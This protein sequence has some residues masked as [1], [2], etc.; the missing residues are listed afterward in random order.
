MSW[1]AG[2]RD[3]NEAEIVSALVKAGCDVDY[4]SFKPYD[5]VV[6]RSSQSY[7]L[8]VKTKKGRMRQ[9]QVDFKRD[10]RGHYA[11]VRTPEEAL[12][13]VGL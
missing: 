4:V 8:E 7:L 11:V 1:G 10:W 3:N 13:A 12:K 2:R 5:I 9:S 6:G